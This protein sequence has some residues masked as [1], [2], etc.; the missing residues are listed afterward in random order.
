MRRTISTILIC[1]LLAGDVLAVDRKKAVY[2]GGTIES[3][4]KHK[5]ATEGEL[6]LKNEKALIFNVKGQAIEV[7]YDRIA[8]LEYQKT[9]HY[10][11]ALIGSTVGVTAMSATAVLGIAGVFVLFPV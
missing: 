3:F 8:A 11:A 9:A 1:S 7:A 2:V 6:D 4:N 5:K 10:R